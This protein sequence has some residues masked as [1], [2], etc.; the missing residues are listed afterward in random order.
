MVLVLLIA[1]AV[2]GGTVCAQ[3]TAPTGRAEN[4][5]Q[6]ATT[7]AARLI[8]A[9]SHLAAVDS[10][11]AKAYREAK[12][13]A[14]PDEQKLLVQEQLAWLRERSEK[15]GLKGKDAAP[16]DE[17]RKAKPCVE[18]EIKARLA[19]LQSGDQANLVT[20]SISRTRTACPSAK[21]ASARLMCDDPQLAA[22]HSALAKA[23][24]DAKKS[25]SPET[26]EVLAKKQRTWAQE[27]N[28]KCGLTG[29]DSIDQL[30]A[31]KPCLEDA[32]KAQIAALQ[33]GSQT[34]PA[35][36]PPPAPAPAPPHSQNVFIDPVVDNAAPARSGP[37]TFQR[38]RFSAS[39]DGISGFIECSAPSAYEGTDPLAETPFSGKWIVKISI[40]DDTNSY[41][42]FENDTW[43]PALDNLR[44]AARAE[45]ANA[46]ASGRLR[47][48][49][50]EP[51]SQLYDV[52]EV[53]SPQRLFLAYSTGPQARWSVPINL[54]NAR[55][56]IRSDLGIQ[57]WIDPS[58][59]M[60]NPYFYKGTVVGLVMQFDRMLSKNEAVFVHNGDEVF[61][62]GVPPMLFQDKEQTVLAGRVTGNK[63][64][65]DP[66][67]NESLVPALDY[68]AAVKCGN[69]CQRLDE[70]ALSQEQRYPAVGTGEVTRK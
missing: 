16:I 56:K 60:R 43:G 33:D 44:S 70:P 58:Q 5:C 17:L 35:P 28:Q 36:L 47:N 69:V 24:L 1:T 8:C 46:L 39:T 62:S 65:I 51:I 59:L 20:D 29:R 23:F 26:K 14:S 67:G 45:C 18:A 57:K 50:N 4:G 12:K 11:L 21:S 37:Q 2:C 42:L 10:T 31:A 7:A 48:A 6:A 52:F 15:C 22:M 34:S 64:L 9:D 19:A 3:Q 32:I 25:A 54:P 68:V 30:R 13:T 49:A 66:S 63:G 53:Y 40:S 61:V 41:R 38:L 27:L 55:R